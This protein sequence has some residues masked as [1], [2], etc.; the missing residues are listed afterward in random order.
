M[1]N[2]LMEEDPR[3]PRAEDNWHRAGGS[4]RGIKEPKGLVDCV[5][6]R[7]SRQVASTNS[8]PAAAMLAPLLSRRSPFRHTAH[9]HPCHWASIEM[10]LPLR[11]GDQHRAVAV[12][13]ADVHLLNPCVCCESLLVGLTET[14]ICSS[15]PTSPQRVFTE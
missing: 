4:L 5:C 13:E 2:R 3:G 1:P 7:V 14:G 15:T 9:R 11:V 10:E 8:Q 6:R 12:A